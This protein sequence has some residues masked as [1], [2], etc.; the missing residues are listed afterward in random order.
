M[1]ELGIPNVTSW[2]WA[3][4]AALVLGSFSFVGFALLMIPDR[5]DNVGSES[6]ASL[7]LGSRFAA[8]QASPP[9][10]DWA[11][12]APGT[13]IDSARPGTVT[14]VATHG[15][16]I[17]PKRGFTPPLERPPTPDGAPPPPALGVI[18]QVAPPEAPAQPE[19]AP[20]EAP[21]APPEAPPPG[22][23]PGSVTPQHD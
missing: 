23:A 1:R 18:P 14:R 4:C 12:N 7:K 11:G 10:G 20:P 22:P 6:A 8:N 5:I 15:S 16:E 19:A 9:S 3:P 17:F 21:V 13:S 2:R